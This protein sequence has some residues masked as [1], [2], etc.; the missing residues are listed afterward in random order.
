MH[1]G[2]TICGALCEK[3]LTF[4]LL[5]PAAWYTLVVQPVVHTFVVSYFSPCLFKIRCFEL[6]CFGSSTVVGSGS[7][8]Y[9]RTGIDT[10]SGTGSG[11]GTKWK[12]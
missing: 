10:G 12:W 9:T 4:S 7:G 1:F 5:R 6:L 2:G 8:I 3:I 11:S